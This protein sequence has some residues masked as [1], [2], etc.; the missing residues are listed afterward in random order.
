M[1]STETHPDWLP[2]NPAEHA[3]VGILGQIHAAR[4]AGD[5]ATACDLTRETLKPLL[6]PYG[7]TISSL[8][9]QTLSIGFRFDR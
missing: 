4:E 5:N 7:G 9:G 6:V 2:Q 8:R 3:Y 1:T